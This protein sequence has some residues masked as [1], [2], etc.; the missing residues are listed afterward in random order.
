[1]FKVTSHPDP[2]NQL[3][4]PEYVKSKSMEPIIALNHISAEPGQEG[5][6]LTDHA[7]N[8]QKDPLKPSSSQ[9]SFP[10][11][12]VPFSTPPPAFCRI[13]SPS[14]QKLKAPCNREFQL[15]T[16]W[17]GSSLF[18]KPCQNKYTIKWILWV[19]KIRSYDR[20]PNSNALFFLTKNS[21][22]L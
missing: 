14:I 21:N 22:H 15:S 1:M 13:P 7:S 10:K 5:L 11:I 19:T 12:P 20:C 6:E 18:W 3:N 2:F 4:F 9:P 17:S 16:P 8:S